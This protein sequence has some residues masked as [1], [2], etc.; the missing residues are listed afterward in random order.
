MV[1]RGELD[2]IQSETL[3]PGGRKHQVF[4]HKNT[5]AGRA[6]AKG[7]SVA[8]QQVQLQSESAL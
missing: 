3:H 8:P 5:R 6:R 7:K 2:R 4:S 1:L